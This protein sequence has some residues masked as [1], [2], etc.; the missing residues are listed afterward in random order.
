M[1]SEG[2][3]CGVRE[4]GSRFRVGGYV[5]VRKAAAGLQNH[6]GAAMPRVFILR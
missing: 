4:A 3:T 1:G 2:W 6:S 5:L